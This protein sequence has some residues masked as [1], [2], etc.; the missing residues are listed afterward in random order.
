MP[1]DPNMSDSSR[2][3]IKVL[4]GIEVPRAGLF[5]LGRASEVYGTLTQRLQHLE[6]LL[7]L[8]RSHAR[9]HFDGK[10]ADYYERS[11]DQF[12]KGD[13]NYVGSAQNNSTVMSTELFKAR[14]N[15]EYMHMMVI[16]QFV[17]L[18]VEIAWAIATAKF[19]F[20]ASLKWIP[21]FKAIRSLAMR[22]I[23]AWLAF[24]VPSHQILSQIFASM[25]SIIQRIQIG[26]GTRHHQDK[27]LTQSAHTGAA[28]EGLLSALLSAGLDTLFAKNLTDLFNIGLKNLDDLPD[29]RP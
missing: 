28:A 22:R 24:T 10:T 5:E 4:T 12:T 27:K 21:V 13:N 16:G 17:Q 20:G 11:L 6:E 8:S 25:D 7:A 15:V 29:P 9:R 2:D 18:L 1:L 23:L 26:R 3:A 19:T 14:A